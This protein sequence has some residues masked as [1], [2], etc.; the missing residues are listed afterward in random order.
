MKNKI[1]QLLRDNAGSNTA[2]NKVR[3]VRNETGTDATLYIY[4]V[5]DAWWG[6]AAIDVAK[7]IADI[8]ASTTLHVRIN[9]PGGD[10]FEGQAIATAI[11]NHPGKTIAHI[12]GL[13]ASAAT[14]ISAAADEVEISEGAFYMIHNGWTLAMGDKQVMLDTADLLAKVDGSIVAAYATRTG[15]DVAQITTWMDA[16]TWFTAQEAVDHGF[17]N[18]LMPAP[19][20]SAGNQAPGAKA[21]NLSAYS[22]TPQALT[23]PPE[24]PDAD[25]ALAQAAAQQRARNER[26]LRLLQID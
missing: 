18:R 9:S 15:A 17:A 21:W 26:R 3:L 10:V 13:A 16:E 19:D 22:K 1:L 24:R 7:A 4:D 20:K 2:E 12:D 11:R 14:F 6:I 5:I 8:A 23:Q 25:T